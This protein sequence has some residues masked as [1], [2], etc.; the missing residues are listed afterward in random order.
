MTLIFWTSDLI[1]FWTL[2][3]T[4]DMSD[5]KKNKDDK[6]YEFYGSVDD[7]GRRT[8]DTKA[9]ELKAKYGHAGREGLSAEIVNAAVSEKRNLP[10]GQRDLLQAR[11][12][13]VDL[14]GRVNKTQVMTMDGSKVVW[15]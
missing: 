11:D 2:L 3:W 12:F 15:W 9:Y 10:P 5:R 8:W 13:K 1:Q 14:D 7:R 4:I 6:E